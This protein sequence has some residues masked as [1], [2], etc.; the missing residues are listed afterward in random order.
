MGPKL[1]NENITLINRTFNKTY[2]ISTYDLHF[3]QVFYLISSTD[4]NNEENFKILYTPLEKLSLEYLSLISYIIANVSFIKSNKVDLSFNENSLSD[5]TFFNS[6]KFL[7][8]LKTVKSLKLFSLKERSILFDLIK[9]TIAIICEIKDRYS[10]DN[11]SSGVHKS[12]KF[13]SEKANDMIQLNS[14]KQ[15]KNNS[16]DCDILKQIISLSKYLRIFKEVENLSN[17]KYNGEL[18]GP[19]YFDEV[20]DIICIVSFQSTIIPDYVSS[21]ID[22]MREYLLDY[23]SKEDNLVKYNLS[24]FMNRSLKLITLNRFDK[25]FSFPPCLNTFFRN[26]K[27]LLS[28]EAFTTLMQNTFTELVSIFTGV[29]NS[30][31][32]QS[33]EILF[34]LFSIVKLS[35]T[36]DPFKIESLELLISVQKNVS[37]MKNISNDFSFIYIY[38]HKLNFNHERIENNCLNIFDN[39]EQIEFLR[40]IIKVS[41]N[42]SSKQ[43]VE[44]IVLSFRNLIQLFGLGAFK[45]LSEILIHYSKNLI[46]FPKV[47][48][49]IDDFELWTN[50]I[51]LTIEYEIYDQLIEILIVDINFD[52]QYH[53]KF[54]ILYDLLEK[55]CNTLPYPWNN[56]LGII[57]SEVQREKILNSVNTYNSPFVLNETYSSFILLTKV[58][59]ETIFKNPKILQ[60]LARL[61]CNFLNIRLSNQLKGDEATLCGDKLSVGDLYNNYFTQLHSSS[62]NLHKF[63]L[64]LPYLMSPFYIVKRLL[65]QNQVNLAVHIYS[66]LLI[67]P[68]NLKSPMVVYAKLKFHLQE[69]KLPEYMTSI[70]EIASKDLSWDSW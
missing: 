8:E 21:I 54:T 23:D 49:N 33:F 14:S 17:I 18:F 69:G 53:S 11:F 42:I 34:D 32:F 5:F 9:E 67:L 48:S 60:T 57:T 29:I 13:S 10:K 1:T 26:A 37:I 6:N 56:Y 31:Y 58:P 19:E 64:P 65:N 24:N 63:N 50:L 35:N 45:N 15:S 3:T 20:F 38:N 61:S 43:D 59:F 40:K 68:Y 4:L 2:P 51:S 70:F 25:Y 55:L 7:L 46:E 39:V 27:L 62:K 36:E 28:Q 41:S 66:N 52:F 30:E 22:V 12:L 44:N 47:S 16:N